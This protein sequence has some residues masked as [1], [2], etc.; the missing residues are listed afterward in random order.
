MKITISNVNPNKLHDE[1]LKASISP[2][3]TEHDRPVGEYIAPNTWITFTDDTDM[4]VVQAIIDAH[5]PT[6]QPPQ[7]TQDDY[8][9]DLDYRLSMIELGL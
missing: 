2:V 1:L 4:T 3:L 8:L 9:I 7:P 6:P 5:D